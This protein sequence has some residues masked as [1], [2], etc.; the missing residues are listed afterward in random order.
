[1]YRVMYL[2]FLYFLFYRMENS[3]NE[4][5]STLGIIKFINI[6]NRCQNYLFYTLTNNIFL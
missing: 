4:I 1:M 3:V 6:R 5:F 2:V